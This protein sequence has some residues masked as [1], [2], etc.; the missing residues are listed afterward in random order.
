M[1]LAI[2]SRTKTLF[3][4]GLVSLTISLGWLSLWKRNVNKANERLRNAPAVINQDGSVTWKG[5]GWYEN[6][7]GIKILFVGGTTMFAISFLS[8][9]VDLRRCKGEPRT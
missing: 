7:R 1:S 9:F 3:Y 8:F 6:P 5:P 4:I 2:S